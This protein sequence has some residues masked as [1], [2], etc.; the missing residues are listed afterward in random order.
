MS[1][2]KIIIHNHYSKPARDSEAEVAGIKSMAK[3]MSDKDLEWQIANGKKLGIPANMTQLFKAELASRKGKQRDAK[4]DPQYSSAEGQK[5][6]MAESMG[7]TYV[8]PSKIDFSK[9][10]DYGADPVGNGMFKM[11]PSGDIVS[12]EERMRRLKK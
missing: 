9:K 3:S 12:Y 4:R 6:L 2:P 8:P 10:G 5:R 1:K 7:H 11:V